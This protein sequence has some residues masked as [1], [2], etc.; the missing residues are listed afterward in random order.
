MS[1]KLYICPICG[2]PGLK[3]P[4]WGNDGKS[5]TFE[6]CPCCGCEFGYEDARPEGAKEF[7]KRWIATGGKWH[8]PTLKPKNWDMKQQLKNINIEI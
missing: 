5:P 6:I 7:R 1:E 3:E 2:Y 8:D 4:A